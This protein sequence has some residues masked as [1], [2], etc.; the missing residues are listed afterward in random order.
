M[1]LNEQRRRL[2]KGG[3]AAPIVLGTLLSRPVLGAAPYNCTISGQLSGNTSSHGAPVECG[4]L[5]ASPGYWRQ[6]QKE[7]PGGLIYGSG[8]IDGSFKPIAI[9]TGDEDTEGTLLTTAG[10]A[11]AF[12]VRKE[13]L[14]TTVT[15]GP[16][17]NKKTTTVTETVYKI[18][19]YPE[20]SP[21]GKATLLA[22]VTDD[23]VGR[24]RAGDLV[25][26]LAAVVG[27]RGGGKPNLAQAGGPDAA[28]L[29]EALERAAAIVESLAAT[30]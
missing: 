8:M 5:G 25:R 11:K 9:P 26:E 10:F 6:D 7:W 22:A 16:G 20:V 24:V 14:T 3:L 15:T 28:K 18:A 12:E 21:D 23:L 2:T 30:A 27:G 19:S 1:P 13:T 17:K 29:G 4:T